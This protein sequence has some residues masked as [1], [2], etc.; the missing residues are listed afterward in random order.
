M[1]KRWRPVS[2]YTDTLLFIYLFRPC[3]LIQMISRCCVC[4]TCQLCLKCLDRCTERMKQFNLKLNLWKKF[5]GLNECDEI[6]MATDRFRC[7]SGEYNMLTLTLIILNC[8][9]E[10]PISQISIQAQERNFERMTKENVLMRRNSARDW[11]WQNW[12]LQL[13]VWTHRVWCA[14]A[15]WICTLNKNDR[16]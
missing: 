6:T 8:N 3:N 4:S 1:S 13:K 7:W 10:K 15:R 11:I 5:D 12:R 16:G 14:V 9:C 2:I